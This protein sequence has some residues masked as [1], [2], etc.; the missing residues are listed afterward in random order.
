[1]EEPVVLSLDEEGLLV[2]E[3]GGHEGDQVPRPSHPS[4]QQ[5]RLLATQINVYW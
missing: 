4:S 3:G 5:S 1:M 2:D